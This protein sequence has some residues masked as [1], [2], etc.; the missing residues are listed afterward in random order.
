[1]DKLT[2]AHEINMANLKHSTCLRQKDIDALVE[3]G[4]NYAEAMLAEEEKRRDKSRPDVI[5][6][7]D[8]KTADWVNEIQGE[9]QEPDWGHAPDWA[10]YWA[11]DSDGVANWYDVKPD[12]SDGEW[13]MGRNGD[14]YTMDGK[15]K[16]YKGY[17]KESLR[18]RH[19]SCKD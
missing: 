11:V 9:S 14:D 15:I 2:L 7:V 4:F 1:M 19:E 17:W 13:V 3:V 18:E 5:E 8:M 10:Q 6:K 16:D 12:I